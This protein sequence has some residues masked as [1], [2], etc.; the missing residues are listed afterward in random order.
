M[1]SQEIKRL[2]LKDLVLW[3]ENPRDP[4]DIN[5]K[6]QD[7][8]DRAI[9]DEKSKWLLHKLAKEIGGDFMILVNFQLWFI[10]KVNLSFMMGID[11]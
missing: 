5:A 3:T 9:E 4:I 6:D 7:I 8:V 10:N 1:A 11:V 2:K